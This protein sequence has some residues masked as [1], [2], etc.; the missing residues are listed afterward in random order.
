MHLQNRKLK[1]QLNFGLAKV[2]N[3]SQLRREQKKK[4]HT[5]EVNSKSR[6]YF[7]VA[8]MPSLQNQLKHNF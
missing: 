7:V 6:V 4:I 5:M 2:S 3:F 1:I 8:E